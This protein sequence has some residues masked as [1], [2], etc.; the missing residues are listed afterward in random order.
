MKKQEL[1]PP[2]TSCGFSNT[3]FSLKLL[4]CQVWVILRNINPWLID[5]KIRKYLVPE[6]F[7]RVVKG[8]NLLSLI[9]IH[10]AKQSKFITTAAAP[11]PES[12]S[13]LYRPNDCHL[14]VK[15][16]PTFADR[17]VSCSQRGRFPTAI[18]SVF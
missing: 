12:A 18:I 8:H 14:L 4:R 15:L 10:Y 9:F 1:H 17:G 3:Q 5:Q 16:V 2:L 13:E 11:W 6:E 7:F